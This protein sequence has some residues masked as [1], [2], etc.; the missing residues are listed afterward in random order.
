MM[1]TKEE[2]SDMVKIYMFNPNSIRAI[3]LRNQ[4]AVRFRMT[5]EAVHIKI[6]TLGESNE[7]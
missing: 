4:L 7:N 3:H 6:Q 1:Y 5:P 2:L